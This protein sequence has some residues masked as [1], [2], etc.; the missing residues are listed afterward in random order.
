METSL[1][2]QKVKHKNDAKKNTTRDRKERQTRRTKKRKFDF[3]STR[4]SPGKPWEE[5]MHFVCT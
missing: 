3:L 1:E 5:V 4:I 2:K